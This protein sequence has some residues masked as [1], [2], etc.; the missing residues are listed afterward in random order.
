MSTEDDICL[1]C[2]DSLS[3]H[4]LVIELTTEDF[5]EMFKHD[6]RC[7]I[8]HYGCFKD[9]QKKRAKDALENEQK[10]ASEHTEHRPARNDRSTPIDRSRL[11]RVLFAVL[12]NQ[13][14]EIR[15]VAPTW[16]GSVQDLQY[17]W[18]LQLH[19]AAALW[20]ESESCPPYFYLLPRVPAIPHEYLHHSSPRFP[21]APA[22]FPQ[23][24]EMSMLY[25]SY[26]QQTIRQP[27]VQ[28]HRTF[29][30]IYSRF[31]PYADSHGYFPGNPTPIPEN[32]M[33]SH[34]WQGIPPGTC[35]PIQLSPAETYNMYS[36]L[37]HTRSNAGYQ[38]V[39]HECTQCHWTAQS[40][41]GM[42]P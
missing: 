8:I 34:E 5:K 23:E 22:R 36:T 14:T 13:T 19:I 28:S 12:R 4:G 39:Y 11:L 16:L 20:Q 10:R 35:V 32:H 9:Y 7:K 6:A 26:Q 1:W 3:A 24:F 38:S 33:Y 18:A 21:R 29:A 42:F 37:T 40:H 15:L 41:H 30:P 25:P 27:L 2:Q 31:V 17:I